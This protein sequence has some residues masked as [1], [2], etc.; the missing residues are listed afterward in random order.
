MDTEL[1]ELAGEICGD[2]IKIKVDGVDVEGR[3]VLRERSEMKISIIKPYSGLL[4]ESGHIPIVAT[5][6]MNYKEA[7]GEKKAMLMLQDMYRYCRYVHENREELRR[8]LKEYHPAIHFNPNPEPVKSLK[9]QEDFS[10]Y[11]YTP[12]APM[13]HS[14]VID[15]LD[16]IAKRSGEHSSETL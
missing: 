14:G 1:R 12:V 13:T 6:F 11:G 7:Y 2:I 8:N 15:Y 4:V 16:R 9:Q 5:Q 10:K 3:F